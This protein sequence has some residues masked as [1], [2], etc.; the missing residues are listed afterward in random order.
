MYQSES[1]LGQ[2]FKFKNTVE[3]Q[4][5]RTI[6]MNSKRS[7]KLILKPFTYQQ[8]LSVNSE[9]KYVNVMNQ[10]GHLINLI[11]SDEEIK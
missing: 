11:V 4:V 2:K 3:E 5:S 10:V 1:K 8:V 9:G 6:S 7:S